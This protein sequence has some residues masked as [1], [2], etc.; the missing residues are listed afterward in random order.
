M[1]RKRPKQLTLFENP[2]GFMGVG[3]EPENRWVKMGN[4]LLEESPDIQP[5]LGRNNHD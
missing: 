1:Y 4:V 2:V 3:L 5:P